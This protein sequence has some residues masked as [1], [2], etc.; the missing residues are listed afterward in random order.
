[1]T[2]YDKLAIL[3]FVIG[4][5]SAVVFVFSA[6]K[7]VGADFGVAIAVM[8]VVAVLAGVLTGLADSKRER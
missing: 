4:L 6:T 5:C 2:R 7:A 3:F 1:M 8:M